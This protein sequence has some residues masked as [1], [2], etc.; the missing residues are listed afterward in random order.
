MHY[1]TERGIRIQHSCKNH[2][3]ISH[4]QKIYII[5]FIYEVQLKRDSWDR[6]H[7]KGNELEFYL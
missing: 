2:W 4:V 7:L 1:E 5:Q 3:T 6:L